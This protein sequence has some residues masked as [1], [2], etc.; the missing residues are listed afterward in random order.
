MANAIDNCQ[1]F[2]IFEKFMKYAVT[3]LIVSV[4]CTLM[5]FKVSDS[6]L[7]EIDM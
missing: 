7:H 5:K 3:L 2:P 1:A 6:K 4:I